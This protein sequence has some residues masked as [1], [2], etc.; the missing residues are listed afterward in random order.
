MAPL[1][2]QKA[3]SPTHGET[4]PALNIFGQGPE[5][6]LERFDDKDKE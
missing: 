1:L 4:D 6:L 3:G 5:K 2:E